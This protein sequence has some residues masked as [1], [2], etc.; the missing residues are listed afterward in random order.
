MNM[1]GVLTTPDEL[2]KYRLDLYETIRKPGVYR[3]RL[4]CRSWYQSANIYGL[5]CYFTDIDTGL[6]WQV[7]VFR[8]RV[9]D[10]DIYCPKKTPIAFEKVDDN[11]LWEIT[12]EKGRTGKCSFTEAKPILDA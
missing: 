2:A 1:Y 6:K 10:I 9:G 12:I 7:F 3:C 11:S 5:V 4:D 8:H